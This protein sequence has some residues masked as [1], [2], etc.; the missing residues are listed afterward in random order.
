MTDATTTTGTMAGEAFGAARGAEQLGIVGI[1]TLVIIG[2][3]ISLI[4]TLRAHTAQG[5]AFAAELA[6]WSP[7]FALMARRARAAE[8]NI[9]ALDARLDALDAAPRSRRGDR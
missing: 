8:H 7:H 1:L 5:V 2:L 9:Q 3:V 6:K 4:F